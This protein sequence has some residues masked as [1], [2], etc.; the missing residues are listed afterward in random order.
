M[1]NSPEGRWWLQETPGLGGDQKPFSGGRE[2]LGGIRRGPQPWKLS[3][4]PESC[5]PITP[6]VDSVLILHLP[7]APLERSCLERVPTMPPSAT[8][9]LGDSST[10]G[11]ARVPASP[12]AQRPPSRRRARTRVYAWGLAECSRCVLWRGTQEQPALS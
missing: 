8:S 3:L 11:L 9:A 1:K 10:P 7:P 6:Q 12:V 4:S 5:L 2:P